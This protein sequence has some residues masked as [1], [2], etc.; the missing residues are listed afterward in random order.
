M[1]RP[2]L[3]LIAAMSAT[4]LISCATTARKREKLPPLYG[5]IFDQE[6]R[7]VPNVEL[8]LDGSYAAT[9]DIHGRFSLLSVK[10]TDEHIVEAHCVGFEPVEVRFTYTDA[11]Q[12]MYISMFSADQLLSAAERSIRNKTWTE[13]EA[14]LVRAEKNGA[15]PLYCEY[16]R[17]VLA[18]HRN[19]TEK[20]KETLLR[21]INQGHGKPHVLLFLADIYEYHD[22]DAKNA[23]E[24]LSRFLQLRS[25]I[26][27]EQRLRRLSEQDE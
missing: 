5:T 1:K 21:L 19:D 10:K 14:F 27:V 18:V 2:L 9:S 25:D 3:L 24:Y 12:V 13:A 6:N 4:T 17:A 7:P 22:N 15:D 26:E 16:L 11:T 20:A 23:R 8:F